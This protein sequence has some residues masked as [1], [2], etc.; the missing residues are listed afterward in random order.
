MPR[1]LRAESQL[2]LAAFRHGSTVVRAACVIL[3][4]DGAAQ[5]V[6]CADESTFAAHEDG[7]RQLVVGKLRAKAQVALA[8]EGRHRIQ[9]A[10]VPTADIQSLPALLGGARRAFTGRFRAHDVCIVSSPLQLLFRARHL[11]TGA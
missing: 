9:S 11:V 6:R 10:A 7:R 1:A 5:L 3:R 2:A 8:V 4:I